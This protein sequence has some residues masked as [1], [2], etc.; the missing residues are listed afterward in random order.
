MKGGSPFPLFR[1]KKFWPQIIC[2]VILAAGGGLAMMFGSAQIFTTAILVAFLGLNEFGRWSYKA[3]LL[4]CATGAT[5]GS[6]GSIFT[7]FETAAVFIFLF[8]VGGFI[9]YYRDGV[10]SFIARMS[11]FS[12]DLSKE[13]NLQGVMTIAYNRLNAAA[14]GDAVSIIW[15]DDAG[16]LFLEKPNGQ[17]EEIKKNG[18]SIC[19]VF[20]SGRPYITGTVNPADR[21][22]FRDARSLI[23]VPLCAGG[24][25]LGVLQVE[26]PHP[27]AYADEDL[28]RLEAV[29]FVIAQC[30]APYM[31]AKEP[32]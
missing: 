21:P 17:H 32:D 6:I 2:V 18:G 26:S 8:V 3:N 11:K 31:K 10:N 5:V 28:S 13:T 19:R 9:L 30:A 7:W 4:I 23:A 29:A 1:R 27:E 24:R 25:K 12:T 15:T 16:D 20:A 22:L 14:R